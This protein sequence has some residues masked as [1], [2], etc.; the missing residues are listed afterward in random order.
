MSL[1]PFRVSLLL[2]AVLALA[3]CDP[4]GSSSF[5]GIEGTGSP[6]TVSGSVTAYGSIYV[7]GV[8]IDLTGAEVYVEGE[9]A[10]DEDL[11]LGMVVEVTT[12]DALSGD[13]QAVARTARY[14]RSL[15]GVVEEVLEASDVRKVLRVLGQRLIVYDDAVFD[16]V[17]FEEL[18]VG[19]ALDVSGFADAEGRLTASR[20]AL[21]QA[22]ETDVSGALRALDSAQSRFELGELSVDYSEALFESGERDQ[23]QEGTRVRL[24]GGE[25]QGGVFRAHRVHVLDDEPSPDDG[26][27]SREGVIQST[28]SSSQFTLAGVPVNASDA[29]IEGGEREQLAAGL[30]VVATGEMRSGVLEAQSVRLLLPGVDRV[31]AEVD[32]V[33]PQTGELVLLGETYTSNRLT[34]FEDLA[35]GNRFINMAEIRQGDRVEVY[36]RSVGDVRSVTRIKRVGSDQPLE[37]RGPVTAIDLDGQSIRLMNVDVFL[38]GESALALLMDLQPG[39]RLRVRG[40]VSGPNSIS[41][42]DIE[43]STV[44]IGLDE[45]LQPIQGK[46]D[47]LPGTDIDL[48]SL[49]GPRYRF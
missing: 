24:Q 33:D 35:Q 17:S 29:Q 13:E 8:H 37:L 41:A 38:E 42:S 32:S 44:P 40:A 3:G 4:G 6:T 1:Q 28:E 9:L 49:D 7:N 14:Q 16:G 46:C 31:R 39:D 45:C 48:Q 11:E 47:G 20:M 21:T 34:A 19:T 23:L 26:E 15:R 12:D 30:R 25:Q 18:E 27:V 36:A 5:A 10:S 22:V 2:V 43:L